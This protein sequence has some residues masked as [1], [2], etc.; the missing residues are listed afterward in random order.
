MKRILFLV[1]L[2]SL[3]A[4][5][6][7]ADVTLVSVSGTVEIRE[8]GGAWMPASAGQVVSTRSWIS[9]GFGSRAKISAGGMELTLQPLTR[10]SISSLT[11]SDDSTS[12]RVSLQTGRVRATRPAATRSTRRSIDFRVSTPVATAAV[13]GTDFELSPDRLITYEGLVSYTQ[14]GV[15]VLSPGGTFSWAVPGDHPMNPIDLVGETW[16]VN[17]TAGSIPG[18]SSRG[19]RGRSRSSRNGYLVLDL[20]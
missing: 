15:I 7:A 9:T 20:E 17:P 2:T 12:T 11:E 5:L 3:A 8:P 6:F 19:G 18:D 14:G 10:A 1:L 4:A 16:G 13:R